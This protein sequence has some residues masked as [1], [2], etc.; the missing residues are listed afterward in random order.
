MEQMSVVDHLMIV[1]VI[2]INGPFGSHTA[3]TETSQISCQL[4]WSLVKL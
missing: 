3:L 4:F 1:I 2:N